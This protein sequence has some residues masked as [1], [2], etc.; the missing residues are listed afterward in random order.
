MDFGLSWSHTQTLIFFL[1]FSHIMSRFGWCACVGH[2][3]SLFI[4]LSTWLV[5]CCWCHV[6]SCLLSDPALL[7]ISLLFQSLH[8]CPPRL[9]PHLF[10]RC[11]QSCAD[12]LFYVVCVCVCVMSAR[13]AVLCLP[14]C[15]SPSGWFLFIFVSLYY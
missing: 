3:M 12:L 9:S 10:S 4:C 7:V 6:L 14:V 13:T 11:L 15:F 2:Q 1:F 5:V 8:L